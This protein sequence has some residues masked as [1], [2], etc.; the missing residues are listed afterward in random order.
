MTS[1]HLLLYRL[2][3]LMLEHEQHILPIDLL[4]DDEQIG[5]FVKS[6][7]I[8]SPYQQLL[9]GGILTETVIDDELQVSFSMEG[10]F[11]YVLGKV[12]YN[13]KGQMEKG[14]LLHLAK[15][16]NLTGIREGISQCLI[17]EA[18]Q[19]QIENIIELID[20]G[21][22]FADICILPLATAF[23]FGNFEE[24]ITELLKNPSES[25]FRILRESILLL[26]LNNKSKL[27]ETIISVTSKFV[28]KYRF[29]KRNFELIR[30]KIL[31]LM[32]EKIKKISSIAR[33]SISSQIKIFSQ[34]S[35]DKRLKLT[36]DFYNILV[37]RGLI[38][39]SVDFAQSYSL[40]KLKGSIISANYYNFI[41]P[42]LELGRF[43]EAEKI[44]LQS[45]DFNKENG[46]FINWSGFIYQTWYEIKSG[47]PQ[48]LS[49]GLSLYERSEK[50]I[51]KTFGPY[52]IQK[53]ENL[54]NLGYTYG[55]M[56]DF[57]KAIAILSKAAE[58]L[59]KS[60]AVLD[61]YPLGNLYE[62]MANAFCNLKQFENALSTIEKSDKCKLLQIDSDSVEM[63]WNYD[64]RANILNEMGNHLMAKK[65]YKLALDIRLRELGKS[66]E[67][68][69]ET[70]KKYLALK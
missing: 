13:M 70:L 4:F 59:Q 27:S 30:L 8:D 15:T 10:Y 40:Y 16:N 38:S 49:K 25:D 12:L 18:T 69:N 14:F 65:F 1:N 67:L 55:L 45:K 47:N 3:E 28:S 56:G 42:L 44:Y 34:F 41:Y 61:C 2:A 33:N 37:N 23:S 48:H 24:I 39:V 26:K 7:Q 64:T 19:S 43:E 9:I 52:S 63:A 54:E 68:Y 66:N 22:D 53:Y 6:V 17:F 20:A 29:S 11:H 21:S 60:Y 50:L 57:H 35:E 46:F 5:D 32:N 62:M 31:V 58:I 51:E 36:I